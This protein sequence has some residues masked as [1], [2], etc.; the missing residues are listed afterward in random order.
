MRLYDDRIR[1]KVP[2]ANGERMLLILLIRGNHIS[3]EKEK[4][5]DG[6]LF[7]Y[8]WERGSKRD[9]IK[10]YSRFKKWSEPLTLSQRNFVSCD[11]G[12]R[13]I[14]FH[15]FS[16][17][18][19][20]EQKKKKICLSTMKVFKCSRQLEKSFS[21]VRKD[22][23]QPNAKYKSFPRGLRT[24]AVVVLFKHFPPFS[25][26]SFCLSQYESSPSPYYTISLSSTQFRCFNVYTCCA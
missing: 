11:N 2:F 9:Y 14:F 7:E 18:K 15:I 23:I 24:V 19:L 10:R 20:L 16:S 6:K 3:Y 26:P 17:R 22:W 13:L 25:A 12:W 1:R 4:E 21:P 5:R 8:N